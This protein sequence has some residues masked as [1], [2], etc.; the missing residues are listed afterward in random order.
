M[1]Y[2]SILHPMQYHYTLHQVQYHYILHRCNITIYCTRCNITTYCTNA[3]SLYIAPGAISLHIAPV[4]YHYILHPMIRGYCCQRCR[5]VAALCTH[6]GWEWSWRRAPERAPVGA[7]HGTC[8]TNITHIT[9]LCRCRMAWVNYKRL[10]PN[11]TIIFDA[12]RSRSAIGIEQRATY[13]FVIANSTGIQTFTYLFW[14][15]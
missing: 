15:V 3:I 9:L 12:T 13:I 2:H 4:Q 6:Q 1:Q 11:G 5:E 10:H 8:C 7:E 14:G